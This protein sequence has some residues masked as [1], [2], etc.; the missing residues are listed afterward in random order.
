MEK[1]QRTLN[2]FVDDL[3]GRPQ[4]G[5]EV[6]SHPLPLSEAMLS[7]VSTRVKDS[8]WEKI[9]TASGSDV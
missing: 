3:R 4:R 2:A 6:E 1:D 8:S 9:P 7:S 5:V